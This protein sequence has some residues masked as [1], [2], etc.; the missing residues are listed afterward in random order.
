MFGSSLSVMGNKMDPVS[1]QTTLLTY[2]SE[3]GLG[4]SWI[5]LSTHQDHFTDLPR[6][7]MQI[8]AVKSLPRRFS[9]K[10]KNRK[11]L[12]MRGLFQN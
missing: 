5:G 1:S 2:Y 4:N 10:E 9:E 3:D 7:T 8:T 12:K 11:Q 6:K